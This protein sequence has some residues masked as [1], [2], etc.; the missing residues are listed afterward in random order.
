MSWFFVRGMVTAAV[1]PVPTTDLPQQWAA[2]IVDGQFTSGR[3][4]N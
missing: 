1:P 3:G 4:R 2:V